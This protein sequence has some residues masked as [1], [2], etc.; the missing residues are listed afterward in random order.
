MLTR[1]AKAVSED[2]AHPEYPRPTLVRTNWLNLNGQWDYGITH[3]DQ[4]NSGTFTGKILVPFPVESFLSGVKHQLTENQRL[5][6]RRPFNVPTNWLGQRVLL[7]F[8]AVDW[9]ARVWLNGKELGVHRG[10]YDRFSFDIT[11][12][13]KPKDAQELVV[14]VFNPTDS[15]SQPRGKQV[16]H[17]RGTFYSASSGIWQTIWLEPVPDT[18]IESLKVMPDIDAD[19]L[20]LTVQGKGETNDIKVEAVALDGE[21]EVG[22]AMACLGE[23]FQIAIPKAKLW[24][25]D[26]PFL[27]NLKV[28]L[29]KKGKAVDSVSSYFGMRKI[30]VAK[31]AD[32]FPRLMLNNKRLFQFGPLD[33]GYWPDGI[34]TAP[35]DEALRSD[36]EVTKE[37]GFNMCRKHVKV[38]PERW[39]YWC[40]KIGLLVWQDMPS[41]GRATLPSEKEIKR[42]P[43]SASQ[44]EQE[45]RQ[46]ITG[47]WNHPCIVMWTAF[48]QG[49]GQYDT[50]RITSMIKQLDP[51]R[52]VLDASGW[53]DMGVGDVRSI[54]SYPRPRPP[55]QDGKRAC[56]LGEWGGLGLP[57]AGHVWPNTWSYEH[58]RNT[59]EL[60]Y[61][62]SFDLSTFIK[63]YQTKG[64]SGAVITQLTDVEAETDG[65]MTYDRDVIKME[66]GMIKATNKALFSK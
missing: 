12:A 13:I 65:L 29:L 2:N 8:D 44:F 9:E 25:P 54:H 60:E 42:T 61:Q 3:L 11:E 31:D 16:L 24:S 49:W 26:D 30:S 45:L 62:Y 51:T 40:D 35:C 1:W 63:P 52:L 6:Y 56:V 10:G 57:I 46:M 47:H 27:Y 23:E 17:P 41:G 28:T 4:T 53:N 14:S 64:L 58:C 20:K 55:E 50:V 43:E 39:Y 19:T 37:L 32:G 18:A 34:Y 38:E 66:D 7:H 21:Q 15:G 5:W 48:N 33:Q 59:N 36:I 22:R